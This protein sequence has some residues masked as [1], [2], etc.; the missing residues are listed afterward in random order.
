[1]VNENNENNDND[2]DD[3]SNTYNNNNN[4]SNNNNNNNNNNND[5]NNKRSSKFGRTQKRFKHEPIQHLL[6]FQTSASVSITRK[7]NE[8]C[9]LFLKY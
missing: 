7:K 9:F 1:M 3:N 2:D 4:N 5:Y 8:K 6:F